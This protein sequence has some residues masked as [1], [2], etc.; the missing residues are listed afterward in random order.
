MII[1]PRSVSSAAGVTDRRGSYPVALDR[2]LG[3]TALLLAAPFLFLLEDLFDDPGI[4]HGG[5]PF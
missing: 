3:S 5:P 2:E 4:Q 1:T